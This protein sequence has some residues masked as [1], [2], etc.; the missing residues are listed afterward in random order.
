[1]LN[2]YYQTGMLPNPSNAALLEILGVTRFFAENDLCNMLGIPVF[3]VET[4]PPCLCRSGYAQ[5]GGK[6]SQHPCLLD[7]MIFATLELTRKCLH[8]FLFLPHFL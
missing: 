3:N 1:M 7:Y 6:L 4:Q 5:A 2:Q 8:I